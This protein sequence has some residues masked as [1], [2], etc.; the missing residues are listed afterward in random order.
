MNYFNHK[1]WLNNYKLLLIS[2]YKL[3][4]PVHTETSFGV[5]TNVL[6]YG[7]FS[8]TEPAF[9][10]PEYT[11]WM[12]PQEWLNLQTPLCISMYTIYSMCLLVYRLTPPPKT[13]TDTWVTVSPSCC[14]S[15]ICMLY[16]CTISSLVCCCVAVL[17]RHPQFFVCFTTFLH[18]MQT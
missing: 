5:Y 13:R 14:R 18:F 6:S 4:G 12:R 11:F 10:E 2:N 8:H 17:Q 7:H 3:L 9:R 15:Y 1:S 16:A